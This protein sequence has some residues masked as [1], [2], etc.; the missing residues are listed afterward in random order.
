MQVLIAVKNDILNKII[1]ISWTNLVSYPYC[2]VIDIRK[3]NSV[4]KKFSKKTKVIN[5]D[6]YKIGNKYVLQGSSSTIRQAI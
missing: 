4:S 6:N 1:I 3:L 2:I 5:L